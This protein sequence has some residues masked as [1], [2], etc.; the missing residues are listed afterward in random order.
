MP[1]LQVIIIKQEQ[2]AADCNE[3]PADVHCWSHRGTWR[4]L[5]H[6]MVDQMLSPLDGELYPCHLM[7]C[8]SSQWPVRQ[9]SEPELETLPITHL[10]PTISRR[11]TPR[12]RT[13]GGQWVMMD[14]HLNV[15]NCWTC[16]KHKYT[17]TFWTRQCCHCCWPARESNHY[18]DT[19]SRT[20]MRC[21]LQAIQHRT[22]AYGS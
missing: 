21:R 17:P 7:P 12:Q 5:G 1:H 6:W 22:I 3:D 15:Y 14:N 9:L 11:W 16:N 13:Q 2:L 10:K 4:Q 18:N 20:D 8:V 19:R